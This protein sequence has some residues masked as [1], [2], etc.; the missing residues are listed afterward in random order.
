MSD[1]EHLFM[2][3]LAICMSSLIEVLKEEMGKKKL[4]ETA[5]KRNKGDNKAQCSRRRVQNGKDLRWR[6]DCR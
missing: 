4:L 2:C 3:L 6:K 5:P 1:I